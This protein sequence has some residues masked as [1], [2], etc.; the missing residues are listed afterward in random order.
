M[1]VSQNQE[2]LSIF[3]VLTRHDPITLYRH[4]PCAIGNCITDMATLSTLSLH[5]ILKMI[6]RAHLH[7]LLRV[8]KSTS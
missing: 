8:T 1:T 3:A 6:G 5:D 2:I 4:A 7:K